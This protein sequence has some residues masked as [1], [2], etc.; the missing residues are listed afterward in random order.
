MTVLGGIGF[1]APWLLLGLLALPVL[2]ILLRAVPPAP[3]RRRFPGV[4]LLLGLKDDESVSD[5]TPWWLLLLRMLAVAAVIIGLAGPVLNPND[6]EAGDGPLLIALD[7]S[8]AGATRWQD[9]IDLIDAQLME[10]GRAGRPVAI[11]RLSDP[12]PVVFQAADVWRNRLPGLLPQPWSPNAAQ[13]VDV[14]AVLAT[15]DGGYDT[16][17]FSDGLEYEG[18]EALTEA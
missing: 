4:A 16:H 6:S 17:W 15:L 10:A 7:A 3:I 1:T 8:W 13:V 14:L 12:E 5:R 2:W 11:L 18:R 9:K